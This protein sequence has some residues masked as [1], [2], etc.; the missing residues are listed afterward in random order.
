MKRNNLLFIILLGSVSTLS[1]YSQAEMSPDVDPVSITCKA[2]QTIS[3][4]ATAKDEDGDIIS[5]ELKVISYS[6]AE[7]CKARNELPAKKGTILG[8]SKYTGVKTATINGDPQMCTLGRYYYASGF[9]SD[10]KGND[11]ANHTDCCKCY[12]AA[13]D[14]EN[15][16]LPA[17]EERY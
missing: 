16:E 9:F 6:N 7:S 2:N 15:S 12:K 8:S 13:L 5:G 1:A 3:A 10:R 17:E 11:G 4:S 14:D